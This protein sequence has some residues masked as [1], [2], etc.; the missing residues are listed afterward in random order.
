MNSTI[1][2]F[3]SETV[4]STKIYTQYPLD[5]AVDIFKKYE[6]Y[7]ENDS[8]LVVHRNDV[9][10]YHIYYKRV[11]NGYIG[12]CVLLNSLWIYDVNRL[13][14]VFEKAFSEILERYVFLSINRQGNVVSQTSKISES[15]KVHIE[16][17]SDKIRYYIEKLENYSSQLP[18]QNVSVSKEFVYKLSNNASN[19]SWKNAFNTYRNIVSSYGS[20]E[21]STNILLRKL[22]EFA[23]ER[24]EYKQKSIEW[25][26]EC[27]RIERQKK[28]IK[29]V[30]ILIFV[31]IV[32]GIGILF[33]TNNLS[34]TQRKLD[35][36]NNEI[37]KKEQKLVEANKTI[38]K[39]VKT[40]KKR[41]DKITEQR[42]RI[43]QL[44]DSVED[45]L[46]L[47][48]NEK[49]NYQDFKSRVVSTYP[50]II[51][52]IQ[53]ANCYKNGNAETDY[54]NTI[55]SY[56]TMFLKPKIKYYGLTYGSHNLKVKWY[57]PDGT[58]S[59]GSSSSSGFSQSDNV[60][61]Y[62]GYN[63]RKLRGWGNETKGNWSKGN[64]RV[65]IWYG[66]VCLKSKEFT[67]Y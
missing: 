22:S 61:V 62:T 55:Y 8:L 31:L 27:G 39:Q 50:M 6:T 23:K 3:G 17:I 9:I 34:T 13:K 58:L 28:Q 14:E 63:E 7:L 47:Y 46:Q 4:N 16:D 45:C 11:Q 36:A 5:Y 32:C 38:E 59:T 65:E 67:I 57:N 51:S 18:P 12:I 19:T 25:Q 1:Y 49:S 43:Y 37:E 15:N 56:R 35:D 66:N 60:Y 40:I 21:N 24:D 64:Y 48:E 33:L 54:G 20:S 44:E 52:D 41:D 42:D 53:I 26:K 10:V 30:V 2:I 29:N